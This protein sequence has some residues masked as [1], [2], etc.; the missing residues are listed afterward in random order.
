[1]RRLLPF[2]AWILLFISYSVLTWGQTSARPNIVLIFMD[3]MGYGDP[4]CYGG[5]PYKTPNI[6]ALA[7]SGMRFT[8]FYAAQAVCSASRSGLLAGS[9]PTRIGISGA[10]N[11]RSKIALNPKEETIA[12]L[13][14]ARGYATAMVGK[15]HL[16][17]RQ[18][19]LPLQ[20]GFDEYLGLP[21]SNDMWPVNYDGTPFTDTSNFRSTYPPLPLIDGNKTI[22]TLNTLDDQAD[23]TK[24]YT[25]R[26]VAFINKKKDQPFFLYLAHSM[27]HVPLAVSAAFKGK[28][29]AG[30][31]GDVMEEVDWSVGEIVKTLKKN[32]QLN[33]TLIIFTSDN[34]PWLNFGNHAGN[35]GGLREGKGTAW[36]GGLKVPGI[37]SWQGKIKAGIVSPQ[38]LTTMD[39]LPTLVQL[40]GAKLPLNKIDGLDFSP[41]LLGDLN[42]AAR[43]EFAY[44][45]D[46]NNLKAIRKG[47]WKL[48]L[49]ASSRSYSPPATIGRDGFPGE[50]AT[51]NVPLALYNLNTDPGEDRDV[52]AGYPEIVQQLKIIAEKYRQALG[53]GLTKTVGTEVRPAA[54][55]Q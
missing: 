3:D 21:Y 33:N 28:S 15:W 27:V 54:V 43:D 18:P 55:V 48:V 36:D 12:E 32:G 7:V 31:F 41:L 19:F 9:Y 35:S 47:P 34:G 39:I 10:L 29:G 20:N 37:I 16:G 17:N 50:Y 13:L 14:K 42:F 26:A 23:L 5:G 2:A 38:L 45:Y 30:L 22:R 52:K 44:Y 4:V 11:H 46:E 40:T 1:M 53:D 24:M 8:N 6:D 51:E 49:P 25:E